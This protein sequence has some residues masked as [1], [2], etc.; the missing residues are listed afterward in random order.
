MLLSISGVN[1]ILF[2]L[3][4]GYTGSDGLA[5]ILRTFIF[6]ISIPIGYYLAIVSKRVSTGL[7]THL[8]ALFVISFY[9]SFMI[10]LTVIPITNSFNLIGII[11]SVILLTILVSFVLDLAAALRQ[12][13]MA[14]LIPSDCRN[15]VYSLI[16][17]IVAVFGILLLPVTG[18][19]IESFGISA[20][21]ILE[22]F[23]GLISLIFIYLGIYYMERSEETEKEEID[24]LQKEEVPFTS[25]TS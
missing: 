20:G 10:L 9:G 1:L 6:V 21:L 24:V 2:P 13:I 3:Y 5:S 16:P 25:S 15:A 23:V 4:F 14:D 22:L 18:L 19:L 8:H 17:T 11:V 12:R 7:V